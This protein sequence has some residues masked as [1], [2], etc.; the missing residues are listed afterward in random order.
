V[1]APLASE[2]AFAGAEGG[3]FLSTG[4]DAGVG[5]GGASW[6]YAQAEHK[7]VNK[8]AEKMGPPII[9]FLPTLAA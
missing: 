9:Y 8:T 1:S 4:S 6:A 5:A 3:L 7:H 2:V